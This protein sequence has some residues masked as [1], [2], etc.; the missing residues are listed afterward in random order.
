MT[1]PVALPTALVRID[2]YSAVHLAAATARSVAQRCG[3]PGAMP[4]RAAVLA[5][6]LAS[7]LDKHAKDGALY[8]QPLPLGAGLEVLAADR[9]PGMPELGR[10]LADGYTTTGTLGAGLG[11]VSRI[12]TEFTIRTR[13]GV[14][15][16]VGARLALP[17]QPQPVCRDA[18]LISLPADGEQ[19]CGDA[20]AVVEDG[21]RRTAMVVDGLGHGPRAADAAQV[22]L[23]AFA[24]APPDQPL[25]QL[26]AALH[27]ALRHTRGA[28]VGLL[29]LYAAH[30][31]YCGIGN[32]RALTVSPQGVHHRLTAQPG[33]VGW[34]MPAPW[35]HTIPLPT[36]TTAVLHSDGITP[37]WAQ[38]PSPFLLRLPPPLLVTNVA[39]AHRSGRDDATVL[40]VKPQ[41]EFR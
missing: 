13:V 39:H 14:G 23:R 25:S 10:C 37:Q 29:R 20:G 8:I 5:S 2:H 18:G 9:G 7:N 31:E 30:A 24:A 41:Q 36:G 4:D 22:A 6:E 34:K 19:D 40:A 27:R 15:T 21:E 38:A 1:R 16:L 26:L 32:V 12:A 28:A 3:L 33:V 11:A 35:T 17:G